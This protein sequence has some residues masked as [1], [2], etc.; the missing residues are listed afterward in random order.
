MMRKVMAL[1]AAL[2]ATLAGAAAAQES[3][4]ALP[5]QP[6]RII[7][8]TYYVGSRGLAAYL[9]TTPQGH[10]LL[11]TGLPQNAAMVE[12]NIATLGFKLSDV[13]V[14]LISH[15]HYDHSGGVAKLKA[16]TGAQLVVMQ[17]DRY[18]METGIYPGSET[19]AAF[20]F[21]PAKV[22]RAIKD[23]DIV[24]LGGLTLTAHLTAG[25]TEGCTTWSWPV[26]D[27]ARQHT[28]LNFCSAS[29]AANSLVPPQ[30]PGI[31]ADYKKTFATIRSLPGDVILG[32]HAEFFDL[33]DKQGRIAAGQ[34]SPF[35]DRPAFERVIDRQEAAFKADLAQQEARA[36]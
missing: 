9:I 16:D 12:R 30:Y 27:G 6:F 21:P 4:W 25:H 8:T 23:G 33:W 10:I 11:D 1:G 24:S 26:K 28:A 18:A 5:A 20:K 34:P 36:R 7:D 29:V 15:A 14:L 31:V 3:T 32:P 17:G 35:I 19:V 22:D 13:K 2:A